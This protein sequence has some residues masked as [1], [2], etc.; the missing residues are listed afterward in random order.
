MVSLKSTSGAWGAEQ[1]GP[2]SLKEASR[3]GVLPYRRRA[4]SSG[5][6]GVAD[7][8]RWLVHLSDRGGER[9]TGGGRELLKAMIR[10]SS[11]GR[12]ER[13]SHT[14]SALHRRADPYRKCYS[15]H[16]GNLVK[17]LLRLVWG[18]LQGRQPPQQD[19]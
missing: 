3:L 12:S 10:P 14:D 5:R 18:R 1:R 11:R 6:H 13:A 9:G 17:C 8:D 4:C 2:E 16:S 19:P 7:W 15:V